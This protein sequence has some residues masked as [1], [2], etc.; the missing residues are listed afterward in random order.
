MDMDRPS[1]DPLLTPLEAAEKLNIH[2]E[3]LYDWLRRGWIHYVLIGNAE[4]RPLK[5]IKLSELE[6]HIRERNIDQH[7]ST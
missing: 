3:T 2:R 7:R 4:Q 1:W 6:R 5:R